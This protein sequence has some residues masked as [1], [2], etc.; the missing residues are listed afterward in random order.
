MV[1]N[2]DG[3]SMQRII[4]LRGNLLCVFAR[5]RVGG[6]LC[7]RLVRAEAM[8]LDER[9]RAREGVMAGSR[10]SMTTA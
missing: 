1:H 5:A 7:I 2:F 8:Y 9:S 6:G 3:L 10:R 4:L